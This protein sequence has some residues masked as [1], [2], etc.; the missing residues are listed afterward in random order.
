MHTQEEEMEKEIM[1]T[2]TIARTDMG[3]PYNVAGLFATAASANSAM[4]ALDRQGLASNEMSFVATPLHAP[5][6]RSGLPIDPLETATLQVPAAGQLIEGGHLAMSTEPKVAMELL[7]AVDSATRL[8]VL[9]VLRAGGAVV[10]AHLA[11]GVEARTA[12][13]PFIDN[14]SVIV[15]QLDAHSQPLTKAI[16]TGA[17]TPEDMSPEHLSHEVTPAT[18]GDVARAREVWQ[19]TNS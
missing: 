4:A 15:C 14:D 17:A 19:E 18:A 2:A 13:P 5:A 7:L 11:D 8:D 16:R 1:S 9:E 3:T 6:V 10:A 12:I